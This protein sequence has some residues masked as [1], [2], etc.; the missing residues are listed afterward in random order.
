MTIREK[1]YDLHFDIHASIVFQLGDSLITD[2][3]QALT[4][5]IKNAY[6]ADSTY[7]NIIVETRNKLRDDPVYVDRV[8]KLIRNPPYLDAQGY[9]IIEDGGVGM[10]FETIKGGWL[11][12]SNLLKRDFKR[13]K[14]TTQ[15]GRTPLGDKGL[16]RLGVQRLGYNVEILTKAAASNVGYYV[17]FSWNDF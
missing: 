14:A 3:V 1:N 9:I 5:L 4:E 10:D 11:L 8:S 17:A 13:R 6:D 2:V 7:A 12:I 15:R 16:G